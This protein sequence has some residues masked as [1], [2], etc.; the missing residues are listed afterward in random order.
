MAV[1]KQKKSRTRRN[2][3]R[4]HDAVGKPTVVTCPTCGSPSA[5]HRVCPS[6][7]TYRS[8]HVMDVEGE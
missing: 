5:P 2:Q 7:G 8:R 6:C 3:R 1:P 4:S